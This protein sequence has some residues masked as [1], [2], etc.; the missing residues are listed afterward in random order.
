MKV[1]TLGIAIVGAGM[2]GRYHAQAWASVPEA[3][4][5]AVA[6]SDQTR[7]QAL[8]SNLGLADWSTDYRQVVDRRDVDIISVCVP[9][10]YHPEISI[11]AAEHGKH[12]LCEK[13][14]ALTIERAQAMIA[15]AKRNNIRLSIGFQLRQLRSTQEL[16]RLLQVG[17]IGRPVMWVYSFTAPIRPKV[18]MHDL[19]TGNGGPVVDFCPHR[20][21]LWAQA[22][23]SE[24]TLVQAQGLTLAQGRPELA[25]LKCLAPDTATISVRFASGDIGAISITWGLP[26]GVSGGSL[27]EIWGS[28]GLIQAELDR[29]RLLT[30]GG[31][32]ATFG[33]YGQDVMTDALRLQAQAFALAVLSG[34][35]PPVTGEDGLEALRVSLAALRSIETGLSIN[36]K[37]LS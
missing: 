26:P 33:P 5:V 19:L 37:E 35:E 16:C 9:A 4:L 3:R 20:F 22:F 6:D 1:N 34:E 24:A 11:F 18:A 15:A 27:A 10:Y 30:E 31:E 14:I 21:D 8:A 2:M 36:P 12:V 23:A 13:P 17:S 32:E 25:E 7:A 29:L 28:R